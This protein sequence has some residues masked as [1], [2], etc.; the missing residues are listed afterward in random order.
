MDWS[1]FRMKTDRSTQ[2]CISQQIKPME[3]S[4][5]FTE[6]QKLHNDLSYTL[7]LNIIYQLA[8][9]AVSKI[10]HSGQ[11]KKLKLIFSTSGGWKSEIKVSARLVPSG[12]YE[13]GC[14]SSVSPWLVGCLGLPLSSQ[15]FPSVHVCVQIFFSYK[16]TSHQ[17]RAHLNDII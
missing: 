4:N 2:P 14:V 5:N 6:I 1:K 12:G 15:R 17:T 8:R 3:D 11:F 10:P 13:E 16:D 9:V 7:R